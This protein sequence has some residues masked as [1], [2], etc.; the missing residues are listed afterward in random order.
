MLTIVPQARVAEPKKG[1]H[2]LIG[3]LTQY[4]IKCILPK[5]NTRFARAKI[6]TV[7]SW[8]VLEPSCRS[9]YVKVYGNALL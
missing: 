8:Q 4:G 6:L 3:Y 9:K 2:I 5:E 7:A 1:Q